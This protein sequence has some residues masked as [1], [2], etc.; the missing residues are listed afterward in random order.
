MKELVKLKTR[1]SRDGIRFI[2]FLDYIDT[3]GKRRRISLGHNDKRKA[4]SQ[5]KQT[6]RELRM[7]ILEPV[8]M[9]LNDFLTDSLART[10]D[11]NR[12]STQTEHRSAM[13]QFIKA[14]GNIDYKRVTLSHGELF[15]Q[16]Q[17]D[18]GN[19]PATVSKKLR[20]L[21]RLFQLAVERRQ[22]T[23][24]PLKYVKLPRWTKK[25]IE[26][27]KDQ[28]CE[29]ILRVVN[30]VRTPLR[31]DIL[32][33]LALTT[34][35]R[36]GELLNTVWTDIDFAAKTIHVSPKENTI[37]TWKWLIKDHE[38][39]TL[40]LTE[41]AV[42]MLAEHQSQQPDK[43]A[44]V[45]VPPA[46]YSV[47]Q[48]LRKAGRWTLS[49]SRLSVIRNFRREFNKILKRAA[50]R[51]RR[52]HDLRNTALTNWF[53]NG[54]GEYEVMK[55]AGHADFKTTHQFYLA[56]ADDLVDKARVAVNTGIGQ[57]LARIWRA[58]TFLRK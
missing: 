17:L 46:R 40:P 43:Y 23:E 33:Y 34:G 47:I 12:E 39:R 30:E 6:E 29:R 57:N 20:A 54:M 58:P 56:V 50:V 45:F 41:D 7:G 25:K 48:G 31:W 18:K 52:F 14:I 16:I 2:Y 3:A 13:K 9:K 4:E 42:A 5:K 21:K 27:Y 37:E 15:R 55:L 53:T 36:R 38:R 35:M 24:N 32:I 51:Q 28:E 49:D 10:G 26:V 44:Y 11:Q 8:S 19:S 1:P 22:L